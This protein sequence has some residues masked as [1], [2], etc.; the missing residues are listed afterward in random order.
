MKFKLMYF[1]ILSLYYSEGIYADKNEQLFNEGQNL[2]TTHCLMCH[3]SKGMGDGPVGNNLTKKLPP[4]KMISQK[5][6]EDILKSGKIGVMP[7]YR[8]TL[9]AIQKQAVAL[10]IIKDFSKK[11]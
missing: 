10:Y 2:Y 4:L 8:T 9:T 6:I 3:G 1:L 11:P 7:D 5:Q